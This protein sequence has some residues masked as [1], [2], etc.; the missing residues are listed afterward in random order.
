ML[1]NRI[2]PWANEQPVADPQTG[3][4]NLQAIDKY[5]GWMLIVG[6]ITT[7]DVIICIICACVLANNY[8]PVNYWCA[9]GI[10]LCLWLVFWNHQFH[11]LFQSKSHDSFH[12]NESLVACKT[13]EH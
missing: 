2:N 11:S 5:N 8:H 13:S 7:A 4:K 3:L 6:A 1:F 10:T 9:V 12:A